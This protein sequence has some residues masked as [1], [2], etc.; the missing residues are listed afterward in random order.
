M[1][2]DRRTEPI[3]ATI[4][5]ERTGTGHQFLSERAGTDEFFQNTETGCQF[6]AKKTGA[7]D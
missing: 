2:F 3:Q 5:C 4:V 6:L 1:V 7:D